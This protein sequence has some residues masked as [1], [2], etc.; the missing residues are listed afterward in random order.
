MAVMSLITDPAEVASLC[1]RLS[2]ETYVTVD[3]EFLR[4]EH[5]LADLVCG[6][7]GR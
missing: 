5:L 1:D 3:T 6:P 2:R 7:A 4:G